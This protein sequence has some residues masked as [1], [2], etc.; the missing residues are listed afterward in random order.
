[1][2][3]FCEVFLYL[4]EKLWWVKVLIFP[5]KHNNNKKARFDCINLSLCELKC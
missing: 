5:E 1:M 2:T 3:I 4:V